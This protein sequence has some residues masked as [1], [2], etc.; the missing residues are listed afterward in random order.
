MPSDHVYPTTQSAAPWGRIYTPPKL[1]RAVQAAERLR[2]ELGEE[3]VEG[4]RD[5][6]MRCETDPSVEL[7]KW[8]SRQPSYLKAGAK[9]TIFCGKPVVYVAFVYLLFKEKP[10]LLKRTFY[11]TY[12]SLTG[13]GADTRIPDALAW[14]LGFAP[15]EESPVYHKAMK[16][17][18]KKKKTAAKKSKGE[19]PTVGGGATLSQPFSGRVVAV[20][21]EHTRVLCALMDEV[22]ALRDQHSQ[23]LAA[24]RS[25]M[26]TLRRQEAHGNVSL[27]PFGALDEI[28]AR[29]AAL[30]FKGTLTLTVE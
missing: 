6:Y 26:G 13:K 29:L 21:D 22:K 3:L 25:E 16:A 5:A 10:S 17:R 2:E 24:L 20:L 11:T 14:Y 27:D 18:A 23:E 19:V 9:R 30:G 7:W 1:Q 12:K 8:A 15:P 4:F 28:K